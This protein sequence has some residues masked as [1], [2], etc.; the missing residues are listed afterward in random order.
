MTLLRLIAAAIAGWLLW[1][2]L[3]RRS[4]GDGSATPRGKDP[5]ERYG[6]LTDQP[7]EDADFEDIPRR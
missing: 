2:W 1:S 6:D 5:G 3:F 7:I 4:G